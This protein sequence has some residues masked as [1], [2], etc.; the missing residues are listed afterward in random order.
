MLMRRSINLRLTVIATMLAT[1]LL[2]MGCQPDLPSANQNEESIKITQP[3]ISP[4]AT[5][6]TGMATET[7]MPTLSPSPTLTP[8][9]SLPPVPENFIVEDGLWYEAAFL[10]W[11]DGEL[12]KNVIFFPDISV[13]S[14]LYAP[15]SG[16]LHI[17][18]SE[19]SFGRHAEITIGDVADW[20]D[21]GPSGRYI[22]FAAQEFELLDIGHKDG[23][24]F[25]EKGRAFAEV[26]KKAELFPGTYEQKP[27]LIVN[28]DKAWADMIDDSIEDPREYAWSAVQIYETE[29]DKGE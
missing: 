5:V 16:Y 8:T 12:Y 4:T 25:V 23:Q 18:T 15:M 10:R 26:T 19:G 14:M 28:F 11:T 17:A 29:I 22:T 21:S 3:I 24:F 20:P 9:M 27:E 6:P 2:F 13:G 7:A 1:T